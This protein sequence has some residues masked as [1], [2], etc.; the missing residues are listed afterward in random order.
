M[1]RRIGSAV[2][3]TA[4]VL[5]CAGRLLAPFDSRLEGVALAQDKPADE[6]H[7]RVYQ[8]TVDSVVAVRALAPL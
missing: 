8:K 2:L 7:K 1:P 3:G 5:L 6:V 4:L